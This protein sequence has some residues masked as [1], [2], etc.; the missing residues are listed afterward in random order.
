MREPLILLVVIA[1]FAIAWYVRR[2]SAKPAA[3]PKTDGPRR[4]TAKETQ[5]DH[6][7]V[8]VPVSQP[9]A[10]APAPEP[11]P[12]TEG[13]GLFREAAASA[14]GVPYVRAAD[15]LEDLTADLKNARRD[16]ERAA[17]RLANSAST[18]LAAIQAA[19]AA[20]G[21]AVPGDGSDG[22]PPSYQVKATLTTM[23]YCNP[24]EPSYD[25]TVAE[26]CFLSAAAAETAGFTHSGDEGQVG[27]D[28][29]VVEDRM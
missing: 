13:A 26:V 15:Q 28:A 5:A 1:V 20:R 29:I 21:G 24:G 9:E 6:A 25:R 14:A 19:D 22:C 16:A 23:R 8:T 17:E 7:S 3:Q 12:P 10:R 2:V 4:L 27:S 11:G 18:A